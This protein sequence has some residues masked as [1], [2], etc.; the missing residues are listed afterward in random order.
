MTVKGLKSDPDL[1]TAIARGSYHEWVLVSKQRPN[2]GCKGSISLWDQDN[3]PNNVRFA[4]AVDFCEMTIYIYIYTPIRYGF[5]ICAGI[6]TALVLSY[7]SL[8]F[9]LLVNRG[10]RYSV[11]CPNHYHMS[12]HTVPKSSYLSICQCDMKLYCV[13]TCPLKKCTSGLY[14]HRVLLEML[15]KVLSQLP[16]SICQ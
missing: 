14:E 5:I 3:D 15:S 16:S 13:S 2:S 4:I 12:Y 10:T 6:Y 1:Q 11:S 7:R 8:V 9:F